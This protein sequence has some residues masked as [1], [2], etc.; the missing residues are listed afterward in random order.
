MCCNCFDSQR[1][2]KIFPEVYFSKI[3]MSKKLFERSNWMLQAKPYLAKPI[4]FKLTHS[5]KICTPLGRNITR[6]SCPPP[7]AA[8]TFHDGLPPPR[9]PTQHPCQECSDC[10]TQ[11][12]QILVSECERSLPYVWLG[13]S[14]TPA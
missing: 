6:K 11:V 14:L 2:A 5:L 4:F 9:K 8:L 12:S 3:C 1:F 13:P 10:C 7:Q